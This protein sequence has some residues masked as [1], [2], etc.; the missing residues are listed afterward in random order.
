MAK[1][2]GVPTLLKVAMRLC[3]LLN[4]YGPVISVLYPDNTALRTALVAAQTA[5]SELADELA[6][7]KE[8]GD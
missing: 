5:C 7:V 1:R 4:R 2:T 6:L 3:K 8:W